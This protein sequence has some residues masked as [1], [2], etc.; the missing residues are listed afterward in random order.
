MPASSFF[1]APNGERTSCTL[2]PLEPGHRQLRGG[3]SPTPRPPAAYSGHRNAPG[4]GGIARGRSTRGECLTQ[5]D[6]PPSHLWNG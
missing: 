4:R 3:G 2:T 1:S 6:S 5:S